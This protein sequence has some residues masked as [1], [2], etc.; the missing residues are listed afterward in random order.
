[1]PVEVR[2]DWTAGGGPE[3]TFIQLRPNVFIAADSEIHL[4]PNTFMVGDDDVQPRVAAEQVSTESSH[5]ASFA[6]P[7]VEA[8]TKDAYSFDLAGDEVSLSLPAPFVDPK[9]LLERLAL[10][11]Q[12]CEM[13][14]SGK[15]P[16]R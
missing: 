6:K 10:M 13:V 1:M 14:R 9:P 16:F 4:R 15:G 2:T 3:R 8:L 7:I 11:A 12:L 5:V